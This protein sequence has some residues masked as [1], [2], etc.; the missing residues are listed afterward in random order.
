MSLHCFVA[1]ALEIISLSQM[2]TVKEIYNESSI[3][4]KF[5]F[6]DNSRNIKKQNSHI[7]N[8]F[9]KFNAFR[10]SIQITHIHTT[11]RTM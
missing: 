3:I 8:H 10:C 9:G 5:H 2:A 1:D 11:R 6:F 4:N 7:M